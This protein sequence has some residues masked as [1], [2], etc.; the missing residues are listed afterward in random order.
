[1]KIRKGETMTRLRTVVI[2]MGER[3]RIHLS[4]FRRLPELFEIVGI[5][6]RKKEHLERVKKEFD[7]P[8][9]VFWYDAESMMDQLRPDVMAFATM[10]HI[11]LPLVEM[12]S[13]YKV[14]GL[15]FE[16]PMAVSLEEAAQITR[17]CEACGIKAVVC[18]QHKYLRAFLKLKKTLENGEIGNVQKIEAS[19]QPHAAQ[20]GTHYIDYLIWAAGAKA[21]SITGHVHGSFYLS[22]SHP[23]PDFVSMEMILENGIRGHIE[24]GYWA[25]QHAVHDVGFTYGAAVPE[26]WMDDRLTVYGDKGYVWASCDGRFAVFSPETAPDIRRENFGIFFGQEQYEAQ[27][28]YTEAFARW[29]T[30]QQKEHPNDVRL[31][32][33]GY[34]ILSAAYISA[35]ERKRVDLPLELPLTYDPV[36]VLKNKLKPVQY[37]KWKRMEGTE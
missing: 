28:R 13:R 3:G 18:Q 36:C 11:R 32:Y 20:L 25:E 22:D 27:V 17:L 35:I 12:A 31:A 8:E 2:G 7:L 23:S 21:V 34:E 24:C 4:A 16:K 29:V 6:D 30:G 33:H 19:C 1:M 26:Y 10:P 5:C 37:R 9:N 15:M 14:K